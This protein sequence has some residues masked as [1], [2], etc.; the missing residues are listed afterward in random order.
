MASTIKRNKLSFNQPLNVILRIATASKKSR[1]DG[2]NNTYYLVTNLTKTILILF[3]FVA[4]P[5]CSFADTCSIARIDLVTA[6]TLHPQMSLFDYNRLGF[7]KVKFGLSDL[8]FNKKVKELIINAPNKDEEIN[9][10]TQ[11]IE[12]LKIEIKK[13][14]DKEE[15]SAIKEKLSIQIS[16][17]QQKLEELNFAID[18]PEITNLTETR[19]ILSKISKDVDEEIEKIAKEQKLDIVF[20]D[21]EP[22]NN[23]LP[24]FYTRKAFINCGKYGIVSEYYNYF[25]AANKYQQQQ[26]LPSSYFIS[27]IFEYSKCPDFIKSLPLRSK[28][29]IL[30]ETKDIT[31]DVIK[32]IY[33]KYE[34]SQ[35]IIKNIEKFYILIKDERK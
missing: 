23:I 6:L 5:I 14:P 17:A 30:S 24:D 10:L 21:W 35:E 27:N 28:P 1:N 4:W 7:Y 25:T 20:N 31:L 11:D 2:F 19:E 33:S 16:E 12:N 26:I 18:N 15:N 22:T 34:I 29:I 9:K 3:F 13:L 8:E 32:N